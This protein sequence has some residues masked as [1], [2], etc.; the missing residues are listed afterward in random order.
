[1]CALP[2]KGS[3]RTHTWAAH[4]VQQSLLFAWQACMEQGNPAPAFRKGMKPSK[5][6]KHPDTAVK[7][8]MQQQ[9]AGRSMTILMSHLEPVSLLLKLQ[10]ILVEVM[11]NIIV[12]LTDHVNMTLHTSDPAYLYNLFCMLLGA[13]LHTL[14]CLVQIVASPTDICISAKIPE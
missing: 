1:M 8:Y 12:L 5:L 3:K 7:R 6:C 2:V 4:D 14:A 10:G 11:L 13:M 9:N